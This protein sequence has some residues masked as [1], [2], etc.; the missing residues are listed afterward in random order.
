MSKFCGKCGNEI[1]EESTFCTNCGAVLEKPK[2]TETGTVI[3]RKKTAD[4]QSIVKLG[5]AVVVIIAI[6]SIFKNVVCVPGYEKPLKA[7]C[8]AIN[9]NSAKKYINTFTE[10]LQEY[11]DSE[12]L[13]EDFEEVKKISYEILG[14]TTISMKSMDEWSDLL[15][16]TLDYNIEELVTMEVKVDYETVDG[17]QDDYESD[18]SVVKI[19]GKWYAF[20][21]IY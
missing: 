6:I 10:D 18:F 2:E 15:G 4:R 11:Y 3:V 8:E 14:T 19:N 21:S 13:K 16:E 5:V 7:Q 20:D 12:D 1:M 9:K 17:D